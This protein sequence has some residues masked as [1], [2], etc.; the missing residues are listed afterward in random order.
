MERE[1][2]DFLLQQIQ[3]KQKHKKKKKNKMTDEEYRINRQLV[4]NAKGDDILK[5]D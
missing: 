4:K 1:N 2:Q 5:D 3:D